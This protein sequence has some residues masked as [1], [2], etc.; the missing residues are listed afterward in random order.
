[1][2]LFTPQTGLLGGSLIGLSASLLLLGSGEILGMSGI[3]SSS[4]LHPKK[5]IT[6]SKQK[7]KLAFLASFVVSSRIFSK[8]FPTNDLISN[9]IP[10]VSKLGHL[11]AGF[12]V[13]LGTKVGN[14]CTSGHGICGLARFSKRSLTAVATFMLTGILSATMIGSKLNHTMIFRD[15]AAS[16]VSEFL[17]ASASTNLSSAFAA[18]L[19]SLYL[20]S[21]TL[22]A[23]SKDIDRTS[24]IKDIVASISAS[25]FSGGLLI[26]GMV[27]VPKILDFLNMQNVLENKWDPTLFVVMGAGLFFSFCGYQFVA[28]HNFLKNTIL[29]KTPPLLEKSCHTFEVPSRKSIDFKLILG[30][31]LFGL[32]W[33][34]GGICPG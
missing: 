1:M 22:S 30:A 23:S 8:Y 7:W 28:G 20:A 16:E 14:G 25:M 2:S 29:F 19:L 32:G 10:L 4:I 12:L 18:G 3:I 21:S 15:L 11:V 5:T 13:G 27:K 24:Y 26:S 6:S 9:N 31:T 34:I 17:P 33:G